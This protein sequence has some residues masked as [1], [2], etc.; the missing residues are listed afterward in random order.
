MNSFD[1]L[2]IVR[3]FNDG[4][5]TTSQKSLLFII[6][7]HLGE[8]NFAFV[9]LE[10][11]SH[12]AAL[13]KDK[14]VL[15]LKKMLNLGYINKLPPSDGYKSNRYSINMELI[16]TSSQK[17]PVAKSN[18]SSSQ[19]QLDQELKAT[20]EVANSYPKEIERNIKKYKEREEPLSLS[21][22]YPNQ[23]HIEFAQKWGIDMPKELEAFNNIWDGKKNKFTFTR[24]LENAKTY[25]DKQ[26][27]PNG[28]VE[29]LKS[30]LKKPTQ[31]EIENEPCSKCKRPR[32]YC[33]CTY[34]TPEHARSQIA[35]IM[36]GLTGKM[37]YRGN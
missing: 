23:E 33:E 5:I 2:A 13:V 4:I 32:K 29:Q 12:E 24:W 18:R 1:R 26:K 19:K 27:K 36:K 16:A 14:V 35:E 17:Q 30:P 8:N 28:Q 15:N 10:T 25:L 3:S 11:L 20:S 22:F 31:E 7:S 9:S 37:N 34:S 21:S 6:A